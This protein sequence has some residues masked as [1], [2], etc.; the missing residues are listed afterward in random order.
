[1][2][3]PARSTMKARIAAGSLT[4]VMWPSSDL[5]LSTHSSK[6]RCVHMPSGSLSNCRAPA[7][8]DNGLASGTG[9]GGMKPVTCC[10]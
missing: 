7:S 9:A 2:K 4:M 10:R 6:W 1:M 5:P 3:L 8:R